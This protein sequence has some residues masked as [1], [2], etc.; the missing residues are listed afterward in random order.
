MI[1][2]LVRHIPP[3]KGTQYPSL[4]L[5][6]SPLSLLVGLSGLPLDQNSA[7]RRTFFIPHENVSFLFGGRSSAGT[8]FSIFRA[9]MSG[10]RR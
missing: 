8:G 5:V 1:E 2:C 10:H 9:F 3:F 6:R 4:R 7:A